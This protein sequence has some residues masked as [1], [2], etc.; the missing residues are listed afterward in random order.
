MKIKALFFTALQEY[1]TKG[2]EVVCFHTLS[3]FFVRVDSKG[4]RRRRLGAGVAK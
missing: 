1:Q 4:V 2:V 3:G